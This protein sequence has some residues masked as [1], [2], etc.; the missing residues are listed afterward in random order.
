MSLPSY[1]AASPR[2]RKQRQRPRL[3][4]AALCAGATA[5]SGWVLQP[6]R[7]QLR[8]GT[9]RRD[10]QRQP[11]ETAH[12]AMHC[13]GRVPLG[14]GEATAYKGRQRNGRIAIASGATML[15]T[16]VIVSPS[17]HA[18]QGW[19]HVIE[20][21]PFTITGEKCAR[22][23]LKRQFFSVCCRL[24]PSGSWQRS[25]VHRLPFVLRTHPLGP[26]HP[27]YPSASPPQPQLQ[28]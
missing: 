6:R 27:Q 10:T 23:Y 28:Q 4:I 15:S 1:R 24:P 25:Q 20:L 22:F 18:A 13:R 26:S 17:S 9:R 21:H 14:R 16:V 19:G 8:R 3:I 7:A 11:E 2:I 5:C 12:G